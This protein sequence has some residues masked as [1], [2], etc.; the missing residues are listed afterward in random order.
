MCGMKGTAVCGMRGTAVY[1]ERYCCV[2]GM[3]GTAVCC[4]TFS[5]C[6]WR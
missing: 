6:G 2:C 1:D 3:S 5:Q 4:V